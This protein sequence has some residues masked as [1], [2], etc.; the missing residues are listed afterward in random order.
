MGIPQITEKTAGVKEEELVDLTRALR[1]AQAAYGIEGICT[2]AL[3]S[4]YQKSRVERICSSLG[5]ECLSP[6]W[7][8]DPETHLRRL[9]RDGFLVSVVSV[10]A[11]GL[12]EDWLGRTLDNAA[13][14]DLVLLAKKYRF[15]V[16]LEGGE[17]ETFVLDCPVFSERVEIRSFRKHW[18]GDSGYYEITDAALAPKP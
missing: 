5:L 4:V 11:L 18:N 2:G 12:T 9:L 8:I 1:N 14:E 7:G 6:L 15:H 13:V 17:G 3:A 10:S 16:G